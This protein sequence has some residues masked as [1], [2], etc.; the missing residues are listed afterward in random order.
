M[1]LRDHFRPGYTAGPKVHL[2]TFCEIDESD[3][4]IYLVPG[5]GD[6]TAVDVESDEEYEYAV[7]AYDPKACPS[8][9]SHPSLPGLRRSR[10]VSRSCRV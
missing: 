5:G 6:G 3:T 8:A 10:G 2:G 4:P 7:Y 9:G 1:P